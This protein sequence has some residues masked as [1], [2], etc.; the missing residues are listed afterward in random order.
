MR[1]ATQLQVCVCHQVG[2]DHRQDLVQHENRY[3]PDS[4]R[5]NNCVLRQLKCQVLNLSFPYFQ[6]EDYL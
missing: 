4:Y 3:H 5:Q 6:M 1:F 2:Q